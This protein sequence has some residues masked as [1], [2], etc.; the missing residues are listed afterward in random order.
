ML[1]RLRD[2][3]I[4]PRIWLTAALFFAFVVSFAFPSAEGRLGKRRSMPE[5]VTFSRT[6]GRGGDE[7][8]GSDGCRASASLALG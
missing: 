3:G 5:G 8:R 4:P 6:K 1:L 2:G 7:G